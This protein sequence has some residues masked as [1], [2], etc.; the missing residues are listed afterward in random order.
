MFF[1]KKAPANAKNTSSHPLI[2]LWNCNRSW[3]IHSFIAGCFSVLYKLFDIAPEILIGLAVDTVVKKENSFIAKLLGSDDYMHLIIALGIVTFVVWALESIFEYFQKISWR[4]LAQVVQHTLR[5]NAFLHTL[6]N[7]VLWFEKESTGNYVT[8]LNEDIN[9]LERFL[10][11]GISTIIQLISSTIMVLI[12]FFYISPLL[13][14]LSILP[15]PFIM[16]WCFYFQ[17]RFLALYQS[18]RSS[19]QYIASKLS[20]VFSGILVIKSFNKEA[21]EIS[22]FAKLSNDYVQKNKSAILTS[23]A[24]TPIIRIFIL[25][26]FLFTLVLGGHMCLTGKLGVGAYSALVYLTQ[27][28]LWPFTALG[29]IIDGYQRAKASTRRI[30]SFIGDNKLVTDVATKDFSNFIYADSLAANHIKK[31]N[32]TNTNINL[33]THNKTESNND[34]DNDNDN[35]RLTNIESI[36]LKNISFSFNKELDEINADNGNDKDN[37]NHNYQQNVLSN[38]SFCVKKDQVIGICGSTGCGKSTL[39]KLILGFYKPTK[40]SIYYNNISHSLLKE[41]NIRDHIAF[42]GQDTFLFDGTIRQNVCYAKKDISDE[43]L[44]FVLQSVKLSDWIS[45]LKDG[46]D[47]HIA[48]RGVKLSGG[49]RQRIAL[50]RA[51]IKDASVLVLDEA[52]SAIDNDSEKDIIHLIYKLA[53]NKITIVIAHR[54]S[55]V[56]YADKIY[57]LDKG[58][59]RESGSHAELIKIDHGAYKRLWDIQTSGGLKIKH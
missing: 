35:K 24:F 54:L 10:D 13:A 25:M 21:Y 32:N 16:W 56:V 55:T 44:K 9:Q 26:G 5:V 53:K 49:Q 7:S 15:M 36:N 4:Q 23:S 20:G 50:A 52:T 58:K 27:R 12:V 48:E 11:G 30:M 45:T 57:L 6:N 1:K 37:I 18:I 3:Q 47:T 41:R 59:I 2:S 19:S 17:K 39:V 29:E 14:M 38:L 8:T 33:A 43:Q 31:N 34:N 51:L 22:S 46:L 40:G 42:V 28:L